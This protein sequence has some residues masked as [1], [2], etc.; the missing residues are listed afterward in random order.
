MCIVDTL[1]AAIARVLS[2]DTTYDIHKT[3][4]HRH[5]CVP[6]HSKTTSIKLYI[7]LFLVYRSISLHSFHFILYILIDATAPL[8][9]SIT[10][11]NKTSLICLIRFHR[12]CLIRAHMRR[13]KF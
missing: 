3:N 7:K 8:L 5:M 12:Y 6:Q 10:T 9:R 4:T 13:N 2:L 11:T 1:V